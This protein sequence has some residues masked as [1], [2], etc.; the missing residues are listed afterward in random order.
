MVDWYFSHALRTT[1]TLARE[2][3]HRALG[4]P[5]LL[6]AILRQWD[7]ERAGGPALLRGCGLTAEQAAEHTA[8]LHDYDSPEAPAGPTEPLVESGA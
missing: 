7:D 1:R 4:P 6:A 8:M 5:H 3:H 2:R